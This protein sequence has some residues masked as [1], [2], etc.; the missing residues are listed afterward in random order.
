VGKSDMA[1][2]SMSAN[3]PKQTQASFDH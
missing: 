2:V 1:L 3:D